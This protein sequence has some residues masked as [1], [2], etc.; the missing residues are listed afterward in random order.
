MIADKTSELGSRAGET[1]K[2]QPNMNT[3]HIRSRRLAATGCAG[4]VWS[5]EMSLRNAGNRTDQQPRVA[6]L[7]SR[8]APEI[9]GVLTVLRMEF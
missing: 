1:D 3:A 9:S 2:N 6:G 8:V 7:F 5:G 4:L